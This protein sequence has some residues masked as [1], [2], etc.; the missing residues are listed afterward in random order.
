MKVTITLRPWEEKML[1]F[2]REGYKESTGMDVTPEDVIHGLFE[3]FVIAKSME[4]LP[5]DI[6]SGFEEDVVH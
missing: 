4:E 2:I 6:R 1:N 5:P 3:F